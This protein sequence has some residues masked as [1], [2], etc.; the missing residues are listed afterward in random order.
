MTV[1]SSFECN[2]V[3]THNKYLQETHKYT[4][5]FRLSIV[6]KGSLPCQYGTLHGAA[7]LI[8]WYLLFLYV[9]VGTPAYGWLILGLHHMFVFFS[10]FLVVQC[11][12][13]STLPTYQSIIDDFTDRSNTNLK[14]LNCVCFRVYHNFILWG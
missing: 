11:F 10:F 14:C 3:I 8:D 9:H 5:K 7:V 6:F 12:T 1:Y 2:H 4:C 13:I